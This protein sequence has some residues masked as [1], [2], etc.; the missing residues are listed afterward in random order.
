MLSYFKKV[1]FPHVYL[2]IKLRKYPHP[3]YGFKLTIDQLIAILSRFHQTPL[4]FIE[5]LSRNG[6]KIIYLK[7]NNVLQ[8][9]ISDL[10][11]NTRKQ[12]HDTSET[13]LIK[14]PVPIDCQKL[15]KLLEWYEKI[16][17]QEQQII[18]RIPSLQLIYETHF[19]NSDQHQKTLDS[20]FSYLGTYSVPVNTKLRKISSQNLA[21]DIQNYEQVVNFIKTT[22]YSQFLDN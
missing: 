16:N 13:P 6:W 4:K 1:L 18:Q 7:R 8:K 2:N 3:F 15:I 17:K 19:L 20:I 9:A 11:A 21:D 14:A 10:S 22:K 5:N 12:W